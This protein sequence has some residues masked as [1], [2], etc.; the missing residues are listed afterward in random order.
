MALVIC[1]LCGQDRGASVMGAT[2]A[3]AGEI[4]FAG[5]SVAQESLSSGTDRPTWRGRGRKLQSPRWMEWE[6]AAGQVLDRGISSSPMGW[7]RQNTGMVFYLIV[8]MSTHWDSCARCCPGH[9]HI[10]QLI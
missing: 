3:A 7:S 10:Y 2:T 9:Y 4:L 1:Y 5:P 6:E 8:P